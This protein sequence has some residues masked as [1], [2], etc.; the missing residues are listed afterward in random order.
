[1]LTHEKI[2]QNIEALESQGASQEE[3]Q[4]WLNN[5]PTSDAQPEP[6][7]KDGVLKTI[8]KTLISSELKFGKSIADALPG[9]VPGSAAWTNNQ[10]A[11]LMKRSEEIANNL[12]KTIKEK[13]A[14]GEDTTRLD[15]ALQQ[16]LK[17]TSKPPI[18]INE[19]NASV[20]KSAKQIFGEGLGVAT[21]IASFGTYG[22]AAK[23]AQTGKLL[24]K[25]GASG[26]LARALPEGASTAFQKTVPTATSK[27][28]AFGK[29]FIEGAREAVPVGVS[30]GASSA[31]QDDEDLPTIMKRALGSGAISGVIGGTLSGFA[32]MKNLSP[33]TLKKEAV[34]SYKRGLSATKEKYK[35]QAEKIIPD[36]L[37]EKAWG[38]RKQL[39][40]KAEKGI[41]LSNEEYQKLG[42]LQGSIGTDGILTKIDDEISNYSQGGRAFSEKTGA[43]QSTI[44]NHL[45]TARQLLA[46]P[47][48]AKQI[49]KAGGTAAIIADSKKNIVDQLRH[50]GIDDI[51]DLID[52]LDLGKMDSIDEYSRTL[53]QV[54]SEAMPQKPISVNSSKITQLKKLRDDIQSLHL[55]NMPTE[56]YQQDLRELAQDYGNVVYETR[57]SLKTVDDN[58]MLSQVRKIDGAI[59]DLL[60]TN[61]PEYEKIN[62]VY[63]L[64]SRLFDILD[65]TAKRR[66]ARPLISWFNAVMGS[67]GAT[68]GGT[69]GG[70]AAGPPGSAVG[71]VAGGTLAVGL[72]TA[73]NSTWFNTL[74][75]VQKSELANKL[76]EVGSLEA[77]K[78]WVKLLNSQGTKA[79]NEI[80]S[81]EKEKLNQ[82]PTGTQ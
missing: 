43:V 72:T 2:Q 37:D 41:R 50:N 59:R 21:D 6:P 11:E 66:E 45:E 57:K 35:E 4:E 75:A 79:V 39:I 55:Y 47:D 52:N 33:E 63:S 36:L 3:I 28:A 27:V 9:F 49:K 68:V 7:K 74:R 17:D 48:M 31:M 56:A 20:N 23:G 62:K 16:H 69:A 13:K 38:T 44:D 82:V 42:E 25:G 14:R 12:L 78:Y 18:D 24:V 70:F 5:L 60:N 30:Y 34:E 40:K 54:V 77:A 76:M 1:M 81:S 46:D 10:N 51:G 53:K 8:G 29:G 22:N 61:N 15:A 80:L 64:N 26:V 71:T 19:T 67:S 65:E 32:N 73:L 58:G